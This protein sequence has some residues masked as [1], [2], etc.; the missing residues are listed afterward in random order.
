MPNYFTVYEDKLILG[1]PEVE[2]ESLRKWALAKG[3][4]PQYAALA[5][6]F[7]EEAKKWGVRG[8]IAFCQTILETGWF[9]KN[10]TVFD[11]KPE[12][13][14]FAGLGA[15]GGGVPGDSFPD[16]VTGIRAQLQD[17]ALRCDVKIAKEDML[18]AYARKVYDI[19]VGYH[20]TMWKQLAGTWAAD[21]TYWTQIQM[22]MA[23]YN[24][25]HEANP[26]SDTAPK[27]LPPTTSDLHV[28]MAASTKAKEILD[29]LVAYAPMDFTNI[30]IPVIDVPRTPPTPPPAK[31]EPPV[32]IPPKQ[33]GT[34]KGKI[35]WIDVGH[36]I[37]ANQTYDS[38]AMGPND[39]Q[40]HKMNIIQAMEAKAYL[41]AQGCTVKMGLYVN[42]GEGVDLV[43]RGK[44]AAGCHCFVSCHFNAYD[45]KAEYSVAFTRVNPSALDTKLANCVA[46]ETCKVKGEKN[47]GAANWSDYSVLV[48][49]AAVGV[50][51]CISEGCFIDSPGEV[52]PDDA[53]KFGRA[54][55][56]GI[57][58]FLL[59]L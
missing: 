36:G 10:D 47:E 12:Q 6:T 4:K 54:I 5:P 9:W 46:A 44:K 2:G 8:D 14:N 45:E 42:K 15:T 20:F 29:A 52:W 48:G 18:S 17:L 41:E 35:V 40:E 39:V 53:P 25:W 59:S 55:G 3:V 57:T 7:V 11:V 21:T 37:T 27:P 58:K 23:D 49:A 30:V 56:E 38:G 32:V 13:N 28:T 33:S 19:L 22:I 51:A 31:E 34:L 24:K 50:P 16:A 26:D 1:S 43:E